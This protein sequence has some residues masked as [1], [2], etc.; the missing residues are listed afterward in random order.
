MSLAISSQKLDADTKAPGLEWI[1]VNRIDPRIETEKERGFLFVVIKIKSRSGELDTITTNREILG[2]LQDKYYGNVTLSSFNALKKAVEDTLTAFSSK[3]ELVISAMASVRDVVYTAV[4]ED[5][6]VVIYRRQSL[7]KIL[8]GKRGVVV[9][10]GYPKEGDVL[11]LTNKE[12]FTSVSEMETRDTLKLTEESNGLVDLNK[13]V[14][15]L[16]NLQ[17]ARSKEDTAAYLI[18][19][20][21]TENIEKVKVEAAQIETDDPIVRSGLIRTKRVSFLSQISP[22]SIKNYL[23]N[24]GGRERLAI[25]ESVEAQVELNKKRRAT[26]SVGII[27]L[28]LLVISIGFG[29]YQKNE[30]D[31][32][33]NYLPRLTEALHNFD[34]ALSLYSISPERA[35]E[36]FLKSKEVVDE[37]MGEDI[38][39]EELSELAQN[40]ERERGRILGEYIATVDSFIDLSLL[41]DGFEGDE[42]AASNE[43][44]FIWDKEKERIVS[45][46]MDTKESEVIA[47]PGAVEG[48]ISL[49]VYSDRVYVTKPDGVYLVS[50]GNDRIIDED[51]NEDYLPYAYGGNIYLIDTQNSQVLRYSATETGFA[52]SQNWL[53]EG[54][55]VDLTKIKSVAID[56]SIWMLSESGGVFKFSLGNQVNFAPTGLFPPLSEP[57]DVYTNEEIEHLYILE[58][59]Q[60][61]VVVLTKEG[62]FVGQYLSEGLASA[63]DIAVS[64]EEKRLI[65]LTG[66]K[67]EAIELRHL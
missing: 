62:D 4:S 31:K 47:G 64:E 22:A 52:D 37:L 65:F 17:E 26:M 3:Y 7:S 11:I 35:R 33:M 60:N 12:F 38:D 18:R 61:R 13:A 67:L 32:E 44:L 50:E 59:G 20:G 2:F 63:I 27:T 42:M 36:H 49:A 39:I 10:S 66:Q 21:S 46:A 43:T 55:E 30:K 45:V 9:A 5:G 53:V 19:F 56:G 15:D 25:D 29:V 58:R 34:E 14:R 54:S 1:L 24:I 48:A 23:T 6:L 57:Q 40:L 16:K 28:I 8:V 41:S 51:L